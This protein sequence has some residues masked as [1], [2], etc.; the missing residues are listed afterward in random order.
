LHFQIE[1]S[2]EFIIIDFDFCLDKDFLFYFFEKNIG[3]IMKIFFGCFLLFVTYCYGAI[4]HVNNNPGATGDFA[5][6]ADAVYAANS[7]DTLYVYGSVTS[8]G[9]AG[10]GKKLTII[11]PGYFLDENPDTQAI[12]LSA[13]ISYFTIVSSG[14]ET[15]I[16]GLEIG[17]LSIYANQV[18]IKRNYIN[19]T[20]AYYDAITLN[21]NITDIYIYQNYICTQSS[22]LKCIEMKANVTNVVVS[23]NFIEHVW[24]TSYAVNL[25][26]TASSIIYNNVIK[27]HVTLYY[28]DF[29][30][31]ILRIGN[32]ND[33]TNVNY[34]N[35]IGHSDQ[36]APCGENGNQCNISMS[37]VFKN[38]GS[39]DG[40]WE[41]AVSSPAIGAGAT[42]EDCGMFGGAMPYKLSG[43]PSELP[44]IYYFHAP[45][46][47][48]TIPVE[49]KAKSH[50]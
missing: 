45:G 34:F 40:K 4:Y 48:F 23:N 36:F 26:T 28:T 27:G 44:V 1:Q 46:A 50:D 37:A 32:F 9:N 22:S 17:Y 18:T 6:I 39:K 13:K 33:Y 11:G 24:S 16:T 19:N 49:I 41:L 5:S 7:G 30:N 12:P 15:M 20:S 3:G 2:R 35:N 25:S 10:I 31:N 21:A 14:S 29:Y 38:S 47:G 42:G 8:Y 43:I